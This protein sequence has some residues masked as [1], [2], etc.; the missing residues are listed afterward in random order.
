M[1]GHRQYY[2]L[3]GDP[4]AADVLDFILANELLYELHLNRTRFW[5]EEGSI[6]L[7]EFLLR[8]ASICERLE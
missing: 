2:V 7:T 3:N 6:Q 4:Q 1:N 8:Y 5:L